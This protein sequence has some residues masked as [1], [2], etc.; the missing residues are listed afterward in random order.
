MNDLNKKNKDLDDE[1]K[2]LK[3]LLAKLQAEHANCKAGQDE[4]QKLK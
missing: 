2:R 4:N 3:D 1:N